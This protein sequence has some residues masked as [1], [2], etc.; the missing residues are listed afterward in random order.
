MNGPRTITLLLDRWRRGDSTAF[1]ELLPLVYEELRQVAGRHRSGGETLRPTALVHEAYLRFKDHPGHFENRI[2]F[3]AAAATTMRRLLVDHARARER[4]KRGGGGVRVELEE[5]LIPGKD[6]PIELLAL[7]RALE[8]LSSLDPRKAKIAELRYFGGLNYDE[9]A[10]A[11]K[12][13]PATVGRDLRF[14]RAW[15][16]SELMGNPGR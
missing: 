6:A 10:A 3:F 1:D 13:S 9:I 8:Q 14:A 4:L 12:S 11:L 7:D 15:L 2:H 5:N 16:K